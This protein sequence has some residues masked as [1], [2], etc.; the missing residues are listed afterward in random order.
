MRVFCVVF[1]FEIGVSVLLFGFRLGCDQ[2]VQKY[3]L[4]VNQTNKTNI[5]YIYIIFFNF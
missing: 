1:G 2:G 5:I 4:S 3:F